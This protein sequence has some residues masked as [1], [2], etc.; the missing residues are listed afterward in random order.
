MRI[1]IDQPYLIFH[2]FSVV[3]IDGVVEKLKRQVKR[4]EID[5][6]E[7]T[8]KAV[9]STDIHTDCN[10]DTKD[11]CVIFTLSINDFIHD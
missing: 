3:L 6:S 7:Y 1:T 10:I 5:L 8:L 11:K 2:L 9:I 4:I